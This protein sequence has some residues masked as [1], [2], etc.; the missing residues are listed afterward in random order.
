MVARDGVEEIAWS[1]SSPMPEGL[2]DSFT[3]Q[4]ILDLLA[5]LRRPLAGD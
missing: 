2:L 5:F 1:G 4:E 3:K